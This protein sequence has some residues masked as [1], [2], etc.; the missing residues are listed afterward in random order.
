MAS[1]CCNGYEASTSDAMLG[2]LLKRRSNMAE[3][4]CE[5][6]GCNNLGVGLSGKQKGKRKKLCAKHHRLKYGMRKRTGWISGRKKVFRDP[7]IDDVSKMPCS[8][9]GWNESYCDRHR[10]VPKLGYVG[11]NVVSL[12]PNCHRIEHRGKLKRD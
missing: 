4:I 7:I 3:R 5:V 6:P 10:L 2:A 11:G 9:C 8:R 1:T 12:C